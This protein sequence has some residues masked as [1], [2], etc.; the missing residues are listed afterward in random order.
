ML[1]ASLTYMRILLPTVAA[2]VPLLIAPH[3]LFYF[4]VTPKVV[5]LI[6][7]AMAALILA[8][9]RPKPLE[10]L[11]ATR[12]GR[13]FCI[14]LAAQVLSLALSTLV[15]TNRW[16][17]LNGGNWRRFGFITQTA[18]AVLS[19]F[20]AAWLPQARWRLRLLLR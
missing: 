10:I 12:I 11:I 4:D 8:M 16:L 2:L 15:S 6:F 19:L 18:V 17:S 1:V 20:A 9:R 7:G 3:L 13:W 5:V 14:L